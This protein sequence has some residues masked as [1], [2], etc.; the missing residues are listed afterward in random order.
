MIQYAKLLILAALAFPLAAAPVSSS[1]AELA[2]YS[3]LA[4][5]GMSGIFSISGYS[6][7]AA[8]DG[9]LLAHVFDLTPDGYI[10][11]TTDDALPPV[12]AY[13]YTCGSGGSEGQAF[14]MPALIRID[15]EQRLAL[16]GLTPSWVIDRNKADWASILQGEQGAYT[17]PALEQWPSPGS[18]PTGGWLMENWTQ[19]S[20]YNAYCPMDLG[21]GSRSLAGC[22]AVAMGMIVDHLGTT[23]ST[24]FSDSDDYHHSYLESYWIDNDHEAHDFPSW[25]ELNGLLDIVDSHYDQSTPLT[26]SDK[27]ALVFA[28]GSACTQVYSSSGSGTFGVDQAYDAYLRFGFEDCELLFADSDSLY[29]RLSRNMMDTLPAH[30]A[31]IDDEV[32]PQ[33]GHNIVVDGY[34]TDEFYHLNFGWGGSQNG[35]YQF[36]LSGMPYGMNIIEGL[37]LDIY[38]DTTGIDPVGTTS[39]IV[40]SC[41]I[42]PCPS[43]PSISIELA[44]AG[45][46]SVGV[47]GIDGRLRG[48]LLDGFTGAG[49]HELA[50]PDGLPS[51]I[52]IV[53]AETAAG[54]GTLRLVVLE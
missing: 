25:P 36:P 21:A 1:D 17:P 7:L 35:W 2:A 4:R 15:L 43:A 45:N 37:I 50:W 8:T 39:G 30:L 34:N 6:T 52:Y 46:T 29:E 42:N 11:V 31:I 20:P 48:T 32:S 10:V 22:P 44:E 19:S 27:A 24:R 18:T 12:L 9:T 13:S 16:A 28:C 41:P 47:F 38:L 54:T 40:L 53:R 23:N 26:N 49:R 3:R 33:Y 51:G 14:G 5:D